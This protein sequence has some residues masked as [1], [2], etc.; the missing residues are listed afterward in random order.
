MVGFLKI[1][2][3]SYIE[4]TV[5]PCESVLNVHLYL[6]VSAGDPKRIREV[7]SEFAEEDGATV[8]DIKGQLRKPDQQLLEEHALNMR[9]KT[10]EEK[11]LAAPVHGSAE[12]GG[13]CRRILAE[14]GFSWDSA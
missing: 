5:H 10:P 4:S 13:A 6:S 12:V 14:Q 2:P 9:V 3:H 7:M 11:L 8:D 1:T